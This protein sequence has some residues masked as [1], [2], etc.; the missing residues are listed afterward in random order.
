MILGP[1][2]IKTNLSLRPSA[3]ISSIRF[4]RFFIFVFSIILAALFAFGG[5]FLLSLP[6]IFLSLA[7]VK[8]K[9][10]TIYQIFAF[11]SD[12]CEVAAD[13]QR[14]EEET[15]AYIYVSD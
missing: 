13:Y 14:F 12:A 8:L 5:R 3:S 4:V 6:L 7:V 15:Y 10:L 2:T 11:S 9:G 1:P